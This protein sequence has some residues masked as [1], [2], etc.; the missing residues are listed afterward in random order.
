MM[1]QDVRAWFRDKE[2]S[3]WRKVMLGAAL[4]YVVFPFD[5]VPDLIGPVGWLDDLG[6]VG[7]ALTSM[8]AD[9]KRR[10]A[11]RKEAVVAPRSP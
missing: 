9:V 3:K 10:A 11:V 4:A 7:L 1:L 8:M 5:A 2:V 6:V